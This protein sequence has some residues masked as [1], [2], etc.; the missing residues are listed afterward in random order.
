MG[1]KCLRDQRATMDFLGS[2]L[3]MHCPE[4][5]FGPDKREIWLAAWAV[6]LDFLLP[7]QDLS[8]LQARFLLVHAALLFLPQGNLACEKPLKKTEG[9]ALRDN[10]PLGGTIDL[11]KPSS[12]AQTLKSTKSFSSE[13]FVT[14]EVPVQYGSGVYLRDQQPLF[15]F[16]VSRISP[17]GWLLS[18]HKQGSFY[19]PHRPWWDLEL[20]PCTQVFFTHFLEIKDPSPAYQLFL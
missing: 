13:V 3:P 18:L 15:I 11:S 8:L 6:L 19:S 16:L 2:P 17:G 12:N 9:L 5:A 14:L 20:W 10:P 1:P 7:H 4:T